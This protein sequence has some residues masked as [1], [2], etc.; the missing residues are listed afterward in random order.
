MEDRERLAEDGFV[1]VNVPINKHRKLAGEPLIL[2][3]GFL[4][5][6]ES[7]ELMTAALAEIKRDLSRTGFGRKSDSLDS[8]QETLQNFFYSKTQSRPMILPN[9][10]RVQ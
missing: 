1:V 10:V 5:H 9:F 8:V 7:D 3:R 6:D 4:H 2:T